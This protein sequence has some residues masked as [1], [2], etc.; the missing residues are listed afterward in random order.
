M[1]FSHRCLK[2]QLALRELIKGPVALFPQWACVSICACLSVR[3]Y[4]CVSICVCLGF[5]ILAPKVLMGT[6][7]F[8]YLAGEVQDNP[9]EAV[10]LDLISFK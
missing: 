1:P 8:I 9:F 7:F 3:V 6:L 4:L 2:H 5:L 10:S